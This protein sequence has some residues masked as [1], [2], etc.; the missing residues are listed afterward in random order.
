VGG[1]FLHKS[2]KISSA[3]R[4]KI[5]NI[6]LFLNYIGLSAGVVISAIWLFGLGK[7]MV[8]RVKGKSKLADKV[9]SVKNLQRIS[10]SKV[11]H[12][13]GNNARVSPHAIPT[14]PSTDIDKQTPPEKPRRTIVIKNTTRG[15]RVGRVRLPG[16]PPSSAD[17]ISSAEDDGDII[18][19]KS[20]LGTSMLGPPRV[21][22]GAAKKKLTLVLGHRSGPPVGM[23]EI[24]KGADA[25]DADDAVA[26]KAQSSPKINLNRRSGPPVMTTPPAASSSKDD[27][28]YADAA[29]VASKAQ[30]SPKIN[31]SRRS[32]PPVMATLP[33]ASSSKDDVEDA[34]A[35]GVAS[36]TQSRRGPPAVDLSSSKQR[37]PSI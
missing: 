16:T 18:F 9:T 25:A 8:R 30:S 32:G 33:A 28:E 34:D 24:T 7:Q 19:P 3:D 20:T 22:I 23:P 21:G 37:P 26:S 35:A 4:L 31:L 15:P 13:L 12:Y 29:G 17:T 6:I 2:V 10:V 11:P 1:G 27:A 36:K 5:G 14:N